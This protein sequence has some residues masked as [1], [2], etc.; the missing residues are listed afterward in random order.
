M[1]ASRREFLTL[2][3]LSLLSAAALGQNPP[4]STTPGAPPAFGTAPPFGPE[5]TAADFDRRR[6]AGELGDDGRRAGAGSGELADVDG[7]DLRAPDGSAQGGVGGDVPPATLWNPCCTGSPVGRRRWRIRRIRQTRGRCRQDDESIAFAP[8][9]KLSPSGWRRELISGAA[10][11]DLF[12]R[13][14][15]S[16]IPSC[17]A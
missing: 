14:W 2:S 3:T 8:V 7:L 17:G 12:E 6:Q 11:E 5:V 15:R 10:D 16:S 13:G 9:D 1:S 4:V